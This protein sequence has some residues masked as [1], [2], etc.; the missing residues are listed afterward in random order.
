MM[1]PF[2]VDVTSLPQNVSY[3]MTISL[4]SSDETKSPFTINTIFESFYYSKK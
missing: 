3:F 1:K 4:Y 2:L